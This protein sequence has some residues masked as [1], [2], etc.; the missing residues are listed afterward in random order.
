MASQH[1]IDLAQARC[2]HPPSPL[3]SQH[4]THAMSLVHTH[5]LRR[6]RAFA[7]KS[8]RNPPVCSSISEPFCW[9]RSQR[10]LN[11]TSSQATATARRGLRASGALPQPWRF[12]IWPFSGSTFAIGRA[13]AVFLTASTGSG[14]HGNMTNRVVLN[15]LEFLP[16]IFVYGVRLYH[17]AV[18]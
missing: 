3:A 5:P 17:H 9:R 6:S 18:P 1:N 16:A 10:Y 8:A 4:T 13:R 12:R 2:A 7:A 14:I 15:H 11:S